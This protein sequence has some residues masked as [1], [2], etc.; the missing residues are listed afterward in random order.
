MRRAD[1]AWTENGAKRRR[2]RGESVALGKMDDLVFY[3]FS[4]G[5]VE[6]CD[7]RHF[8]SI[9]GPEKL[10]DGRRRLERGADRR[11][12]E[13]FRSKREA[14]LEAGQNLADPR[15]ISAVMGCVPSKR[16]AVRVGASS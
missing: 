13:D 3:Q 11:G 14:G 15:A 2:G 4:R 5:K 6:Q 8:L 16:R 12:A 9:Y 10:P 7:F 1:S